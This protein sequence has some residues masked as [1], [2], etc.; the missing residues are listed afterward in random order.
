MG[1]DPGRDGRNQGRCLEKRPWKL[2]LQEAVPSRGS[3]MSKRTGHVT[4]SVHMCVHVC[5]YVSMCTRVRD[6]LYSHG[7]SMYTMPTSVGHG[8]QTCA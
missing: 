1:E 5:T 2:S 6:G 8:Q 3:I 7:L 4:V